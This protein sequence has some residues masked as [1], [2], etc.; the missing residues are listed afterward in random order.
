MKYQSV[1]FAYCKDFYT[2]NLRY[3][4]GIKMNSELWRANVKEEVPYI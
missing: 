4:K 3:Q 1:F 2:E